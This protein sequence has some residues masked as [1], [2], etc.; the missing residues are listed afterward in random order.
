M[1]CK[2]ALNSISSFSNKEGSQYSFIS[3][4]LPKGG[5]LPISQLIA[6]LTS[7]GVAKLTLFVFKISLTLFQSIFLAALKTKS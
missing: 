7:S 1:V 3:Y 4:K 6:F 5:T 2:P